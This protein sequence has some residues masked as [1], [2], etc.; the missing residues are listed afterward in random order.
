MKETSIL[1]RIPESY[2]GKTM[3][4]AVEHGPLPLINLAVGIPDA[5]TPERILDALTDAIRVPENQKYLAFQG[6][7]TFKQAIVRF[8]QR[9]FNVSLD[10]E[11]EVCL[12]YGTKNGLVA[13]PTCVIEPGDEVLLPD[14][15]YTDYEA[16][17]LLAHG[18]P[19]AMKL[20]PEHGYL[21][22]WDKLD[23]SQAKLVYLTYP[24][25]P[26]G[27]VATPEFFQETINHFEGTET[28]IVHDFAYQAFGFDAA[29]PSILAAKGAKTRAIEVFSFSKGYNMSGYRVGF[30]VGNEDMIR[31]LKKYHTHTQAGMYGALQ[32]ACTVA[33]NECDDVL[34][35]QA[36]T[37]KKRRDIIEEALTVAKIPFEPIKGGIFLWLPCPPG[38]TS[39]QFVAYL[40]KKCSILVAP[41]YPFGIQGEGYVRVS[42]AI[43]EVQLKEALRRLTSIAECYHS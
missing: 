3:G 12:F 22:Q 10:P 26:T 1:K 29:N 4:K 37:F 27:S 35:L 20:Y 17:V 9:H 43:D 11:T 33:L 6:K 42:F 36:Q 41:G 2:F 16:G 8:Y 32:D 13:L 19:H 40:L 30:A 18:Q 23:T 34:R 14:P 7:S 31:Q 15:G 38:F 24:N 5:N 28:M 39:D 21:P 25:N